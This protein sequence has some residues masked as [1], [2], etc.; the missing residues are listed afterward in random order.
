MPKDVLV[1]DGDGL[2]PPALDPEL[3][4]DVL[5]DLAVRLL[6]STDRIQAVGPLTPRSPGLR[7]HGS[8][9]IP[10]RTAGSELG[11]DRAPDRLED[12]RVRAGTCAAPVLRERERAGRLG[13]SYFGIVEPLLFCPRGG[14][15][16]IDG[17]TQDARDRPGIQEVGGDGGIARPGNVA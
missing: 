16:S 17:R 14:N 2:R 4:M 9:V 12:A 5:G 6:G 1:A 11:V 8:S 7:E 10:A 3:L 15:E 13:P